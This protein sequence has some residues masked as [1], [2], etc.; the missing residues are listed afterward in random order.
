MFLRLVCAGSKHLMYTLTAFFCYISAGLSHYVSAYFNEG[1]G[2]V[3]LSDTACTGSEALLID[4]SYSDT[5]ICDHTQDAGVD[6][7]LS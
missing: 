3:L 4:C 7:L 6:C 5:N 2:P 1:T